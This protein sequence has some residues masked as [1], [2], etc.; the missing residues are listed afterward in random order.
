M[1][2]ILGL[3]YSGKDITIITR[4]IEKQTLG[5]VLVKNWSEEF[6]KMVENDLCW[7][8]FLVKSQAHL[9]ILEFC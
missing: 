5:E 3:T 4:F 6:Y 9:S 7:R 1:K 2:N 8:S